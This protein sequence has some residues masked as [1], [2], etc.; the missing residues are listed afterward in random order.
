MV[1]IY[2]VEIS[3]LAS[4]RTEANHK[5]SREIPGRYLVTKIFMVKSFA[6]MD[7]RYRMCMSE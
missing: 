2:S 1:R 7:T 6:L 5:P 3:R 4:H